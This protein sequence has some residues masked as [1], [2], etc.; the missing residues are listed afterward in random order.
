MQLVNGLE[1]PLLAHSGHERFK[2]VAMQ[3]A[4]R[5]PFR[6][7]QISAVMHLTFGAIVSPGATQCDG[8]TFIKATPAFAAVWWLAANAK[9]SS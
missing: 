6:R 4:P 2:I 8:V 3:H 1:C 9:E 7:S 5:T